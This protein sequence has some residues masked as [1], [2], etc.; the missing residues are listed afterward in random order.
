[1]PS[2][3]AAKQIKLER[4]DEEYFRKSLINEFIVQKVD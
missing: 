3:M 1:M 2:L 4:L